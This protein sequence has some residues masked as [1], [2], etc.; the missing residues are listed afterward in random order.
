M[1]TRSR[2]R[3]ALVVCMLLLL[4]LLSCSA[5]DAKAPKRVG[6]GKRPAAYVTQPL[7]IM[8]SDTAARR[9]EKKP[10]VVVLMTDDQRAADMKYLPRTRRLIAGAGIDFT[11]ALSPNPLCCPARATFLTGQASQNNRV[12][13]N[14]KTRYGGYEL[15]DTSETLPVWLQRIGYNTAFTG[16]HLNGYNFGK[17]GIDDGWTEFNVLTKGIYKY[18][19]WTALEKGRPVSRS[20][21]VTDYIA[22]RSVSFIKRFHRRDNPFFIWTA[23]VGPHLAQNAKTGWGPVPPA[24]RQEGK[25]AYRDF[26]LD[27]FD[28]PSYREDLSDK[29]E[30]YR[31]KAGTG[32][33]DKLKAEHFGRVLALK[34]VDQ[35]NA[36]IIRALKATGELA[37][38]VVVFVSD[39][40]YLLGEHRYV[41]KILGFEESLR[42]PMMM[43]GPGIEPG[44][45]TAQPV[46][47]MDLTSTIVAL[48]GARAKRSKD[49]QDLSRLLADPD[50]PR[51]ADTVLIQSGAY[52]PEDAEVGPWMY[53]GVR[54]KRYTLIRYATGDVELYDRREDPFQL[55]SVSGDVRYEDVEAELKRRLAELRQCRGA[56]CVASFGPVPSPS[57]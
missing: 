57:V 39:N 20:G 37:N 21:Y 17:H 13:T 2:G 34:A 43:R 45:R 51:T 49:G 8:V 35:A 25:F 18:T 19:D 48:T 46:T 11:Q 6:A 29:S 42:V 36:R 32:S 22:Q 12:L 47:T 9:A 56:D 3:G 15:L 41:G 16:K 28:K 23:H 52:T 44:S 30:T 31:T 53:R 10:N 1:S 14:N 40:G 50:G 26:P 5:I 54:T 27:S 38:T 33:D 4:S 24:P 7:Q 55:T